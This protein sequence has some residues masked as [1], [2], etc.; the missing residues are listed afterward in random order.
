[1]DDA[2]AATTATVPADKSLRQSGNIN[3]ILLRN[4][5][6]HIFVDVRC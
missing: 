1:M 3:L 2:A 5:L 4:L 6:K